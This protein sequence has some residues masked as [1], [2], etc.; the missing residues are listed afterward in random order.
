MSEA[1]LQ[2][3]D[4]IEPFVIERSSIREGFRREGESGKCEYAISEEL[5]KGYARVLSSND[6]IQITDFEMMFH[7][8]IDVESVSS[9]ASVDLFFCLGEGAHWNWNVQGMKNRFDFETNECF[10]INNAKGK[11]KSIVEPEKIYRFMGVKV[12]PVAFHTILQNIYK[13]HNHAV[14]ENRYEIFGKYPMTPAV[15]VILQQ[16]RNCPYDKSLR[17]VYMEGKI[18]ELIATYVGEVVWQNG[19]NHRSVNLSKQDMSSIRKTK[20]IL[21]QNIA[22]SLTL[23]DLSKMVSLNECKLK[24]GFK[25]MYGKSVHAYVIDQRLETARLLFEEKG[26]SVSDAAFLVGYGNLSFFTLSFRKKFGIN[27]GEYLRHVAK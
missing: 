20:E 8:K 5:G 14:K 2:H 15:K 13:E 7:Q 11:E 26:V 10:L 21:D 24:K 25:E 3:T 1:K 16:I 22:A 17:S 23:N 27:P 12:H 19:I 9:T 4:E 6:R 18:L